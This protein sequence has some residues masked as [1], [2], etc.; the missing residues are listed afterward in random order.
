MSKKSWRCNSCLCFNSES[1]EGTW[2]EVSNEPYFEYFSKHK[3][4]IFCF[5]LL[6]QNMELMRCA[7]ING[8][9]QI[10]IHGVSRR[11]LD[12]FCFVSPL[13]IKK[14]K[15]IDVVLFSCIYLISLFKKSCIE[16][17]IFRLIKYKVYLHCVILTNRY[18][19]RI[20]YS[21]LQK[22]SQFRIEKEKMRRYK[23]LLTCWASKYQ[24]MLT[25]VDNNR[26]Y[27]LQRK[28]QLKCVNI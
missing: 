21:S 26:T 18:N 10:R 5:S 4:L 2:L 27:R 28:K 24:N 6:G 7:E 14:K 23:M 15:D 13:N 19:Q 12:W 16:L 22:H 3:R 17:V 25:R 1:W 8:T 20:I 11:S 9:G